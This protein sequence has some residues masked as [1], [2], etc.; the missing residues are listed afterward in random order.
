VL[1]GD[2]GI[3]G[4]N[5]EGIEGL[6]ESLEV[7]FL[8]NRDDHVHF[9]LLTDHGAARPDGS[10]TL[11]DDGARHQVAV[12]V[13]E[14][15]QLAKIPISSGTKR[16]RASWSAAEA[17][18]DVSDAAHEEEDDDDHEDDAHD[19]ARTVSPATRVRPCRKDAN[20]HQDHDDQQDHSK[21]HDILLFHGRR[22]RAPRQR[23]RYPRASP[24]SVR[25][26]TQRYVR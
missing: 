21:T 15:L 25:S 20:Q 19:A 11:V 23:R 7:R 26:R 8:A 3:V 1:S 10:V 16:A 5:S 22:R 18:P 24:R 2:R 9:A 4:R 13:S 6:T 17:T 14:G 12:N